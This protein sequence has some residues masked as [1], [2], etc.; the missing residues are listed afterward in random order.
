[1]LFLRSQAY[2]DLDLSLF[3]SFTIIREASLQLRAEAFNLTYSTVFAAPG[4]TLGT[5]S[6]GVV[7]S[8]TSTP[9]Q[10]Q[11]AAKLQF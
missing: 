9:R 7:S 6:F 4:T 10:P 2:K 3:K 8:T 1:V 11:F 5:P